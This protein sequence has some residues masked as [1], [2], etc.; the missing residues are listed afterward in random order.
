MA[1][2]FLS[3]QLGIVRAGST[4]LHVKSWEFTADAKTEDTTNT[5]DYVVVRGQVYESHVLTTIGGKGNF[6]ADFDVL[7]PFALVSPSINIGASVALKLYLDA[8]KYVDIPKASITSVPIVSEVKGKIS[9]QCDFL[10][11][12]IFTMPV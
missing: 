9:Y 5:G 11:N 2:Q 4:T 8:S 1:Q 3:G 7:S 10:V 6:K 12:G